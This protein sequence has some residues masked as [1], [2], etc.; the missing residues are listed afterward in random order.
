ML[1]K[2]FELLG[3]YARDEIDVPLENAVFQAIQQGF[4][5]QDY[6]RFGRGWLTELGRTF[7]P[8]F[9]RRCPYPI[10]ILDTAVL[11]SLLTVLNS[12]ALDR[13]NLWR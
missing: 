6:A 12:D 13:S 2:S 4:Y 9:R 8:S 10:P 3:E 11:F 5:S 7:D 1:W